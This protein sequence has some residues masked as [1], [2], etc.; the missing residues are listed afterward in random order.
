MHRLTALT[1]AIALVA[2]TTVASVTAAA[3]ADAGRSQVDFV[4]KQTELTLEGAFNKFSADVD[5]DPAHPQTIK[6]S[7]DN[8]IPPI[9]PPAMSPRSQEKYSPRSSRSRES[10]GLSCNSRMR[11]NGTPSFWCN[12]WANGVQWPWP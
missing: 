11:S 5:L 12:T 2:A 7:L 10:I 9:K 8:E 3:I 1:A 4:A 6:L